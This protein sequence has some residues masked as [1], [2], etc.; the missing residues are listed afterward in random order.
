MSDTLET[1]LKVAQSR[2]DEVSREAASAAEHM[3]SLNTQLAELERA[4]AAASV[5]DDVEILVAAGGFRG[6]QKFEREAIEAEIAAHRILVDEIRARLTL[7]YQ[8]KSKLE[9][10]LAQQRSREAR[11]AADLEQKQLDEAALQGQARRR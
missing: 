3:S 2:L 7:A 6:R 4:Q 1:L 10:L 5:T 8:E 11:A 9:Q